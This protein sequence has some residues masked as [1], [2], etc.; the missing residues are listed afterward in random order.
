M[1]R[2][3]SGDIEGLKGGRHGSEE[4][5]GGHNTHSGSA[6]LTLIRT[7]A[8]LS[9]RH[10]EQFAAGGAGLQRAMGFGRFLELVNPLDAQF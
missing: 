2:Q 1:L 3:L 4:R 6:R 5:N 7:A 10:D 9:L 8:Q